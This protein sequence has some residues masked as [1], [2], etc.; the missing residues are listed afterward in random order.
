MNPLYRT[1]LAVRATLAMPFRRA[2]L[3]RLCNKS[4]APISVLF[5]HR[6]ADRHC[7]PWTISSEQFRR[8]I[9]YCQRNFELIDLEEV[10][11]RVSRNHSCAAAASLTFDDGYRDNGDTALP[12][13]IDRGIPRTYF[14]ST[15]I[16]RRQSPFPHDVE[17]GRPLAVNTVAQLREVSDAGIEI[18]C[19]TRNHIDFSRVHD[20]KIVRQEIVESKNELQQMIGKPVRYFAFPYGMPQQLTQIA[21]EA[22]YE[23]GFDGFCSAYGGYNLPGRDAFHIRRFH[24]DPEFARLINWLSFDR[25]K[26]QQE[27]EVRYLLPSPRSADGTG[28]ENQAAA[29]VPSYVTACTTTD[30]CC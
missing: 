25:R 18:G 17:A 11:R 24:G 30:S 27:P 7:T 15:S 14:V 26:L 5:Y 20:R 29:E 1:A 13:L 2:E 4:R 9:D 16:I 21:I 10:Q 8:H 23:A 6:V 12:L 19:H 3:R 22:V 28:T